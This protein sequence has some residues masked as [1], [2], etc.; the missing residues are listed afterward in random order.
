MT[1]TR[2][3]LALLLFAVVAC[4]K[5]DPTGDTPI[6][7]DPT[8]NRPPTPKS[9][10]TAQ[11]DTPAAQKGTPDPAIT[12]WSGVG[13]VYVRVARVAR[14]K[15]ALTDPGGKRSESPAPVLVVW[16]DVMNES[17][18]KSL[19]YI[20]WGEGGDVTLRDE[21]GNGPQLKLYAHAEVEGAVPGGRATVPPGRGV[22]TDALCFEVPGAPAELTLRL[23]PRIKGDE[24]AHILKIPASAWAK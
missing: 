22:I 12:S 14:Q 13:N 16:V 10:P 2:P 7:T 17:N 15:V 6:T 23:A 9:A 21:A 8:H 4:G 5:K 11:P 19:D 18:T 1:H 3:A 20:R 24:G